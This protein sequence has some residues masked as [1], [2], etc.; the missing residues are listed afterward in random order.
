[1]FGGLCIMYGLCRGGLTKMRYAKIDSRF[2]DSVILEFIPDVTRRGLGWMLYFT[3]SSLV[4]E[5]R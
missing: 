3:R 5:V 4:Y 2:Y 1:M